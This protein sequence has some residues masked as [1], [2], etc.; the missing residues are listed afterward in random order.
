[1]PLISLSVKDSDS[2]TTFSNFTSIATKPLSEFST[3]NL[4]LVSLLK[5]DLLKTF[6][7]C[8]ISFSSEQNTF[9]YHHQ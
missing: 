7:W 2:S 8:F 6:F 5:R 3:L 1:M 4:T 9:H